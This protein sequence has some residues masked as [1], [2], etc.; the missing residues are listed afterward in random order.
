[1]IWKENKET[2]MVEIETRNYIKGSSV[3]PYVA[4]KTVNGE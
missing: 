4:E 3:E 2:E 1:M